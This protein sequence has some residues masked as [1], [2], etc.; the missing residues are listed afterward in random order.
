MPVT[1]KMYGLSLQSLASGEI[2]FGT[3][4]IKALLLDSTYVPDQ[5][6]HRYRASLSGEV[7]GTGYTSGGVTL[8]NK[9]ITYD[10]SSNTLSLDADNPSWTGLT[11]T[12][13]YVVFYVST[14]I[15]STASLLSYVD[16][17][18]DVV[19]SGTTLTYTIPSGGFYQL[20]AA[21]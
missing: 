3:A 6:L 21:A 5:D 8:T 20:T 14:G 1:S 11:V 18:A 7:T 4:T 13:R 19:V 17:G 9:Q 16:A 12:F 2:N 10:G 15:S